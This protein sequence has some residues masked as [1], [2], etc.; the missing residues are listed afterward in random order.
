MNILLLILSTYLGEVDKEIRH[1]EDKISPLIV[2]VH[3]Q[4][5]NI[6]MTGT[7]IDA[8]NIVTVCFLREGEPCR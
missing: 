2:T 8:N 5:G 3:T 7:V 4:E 1:L 6:S